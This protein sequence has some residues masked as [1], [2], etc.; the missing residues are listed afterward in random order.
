MIGGKIAGG[1]A[2][3]MPFGAVLNGLGMMRGGVCDMF[4]PFAQILQGMNTTLPGSE[5]A[6]AQRRVVAG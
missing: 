5:E 2:R 3:Q 1:V 6:I 4:G